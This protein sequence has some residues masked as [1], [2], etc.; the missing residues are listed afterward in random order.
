MKDIEVDSKGL[1]HAPTQPG[2][3]A[4]IDFDLIKRKQIAV[5]D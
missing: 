5:L 4:E 1:V 2:L 3:G